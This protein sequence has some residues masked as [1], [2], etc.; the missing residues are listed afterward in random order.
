MS[1]GIAVA[2]IV[3]IK[4]LRRNGGETAATA[5]NRQFFLHFSLNYTF[6]NHLRQT[7]FFQKNFL[8]FALST[9]D[10]LNSKIFEILQVSNAKN[11]RVLF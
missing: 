3:F 2:F 10:I 11:I 1:F 5:E 9:C 4:E 7:Y 6:L 8:T